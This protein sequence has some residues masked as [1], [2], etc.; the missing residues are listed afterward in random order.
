MQP[1]CAFSHS[2]FKRTH[3]LLSVLQL[4]LLLTILHPFTIANEIRQVV[5]TWL[6]VRSPVM[7]RFPTSICYDSHLLLRRLDKAEKQNQQ[8]AFIQTSTRWDFSKVSM[9]KPPEPH[10]R[11]YQGPPVYTILV[12][13]TVILHGL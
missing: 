8:L 9:P 5:N 12:H 3:H 11:L 6:R 2:L 1:F 10:L 13:S 4:P 7:E